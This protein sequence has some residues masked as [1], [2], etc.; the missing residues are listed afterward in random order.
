MA[1]SLCKAPK[2][3]FIKSS[4]NIAKLLADVVSM[5]THVCCL[6]LFLAHLSLEN[7]VMVVSKFSTDLNLA[8]KVSIGTFLFLGYS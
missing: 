7:T 5:T 1:R 6:I 4:K 3:V 8:V 2:T